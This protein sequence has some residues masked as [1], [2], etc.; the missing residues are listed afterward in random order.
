M[1]VLEELRPMRR[2]QPKGEKA[3]SKP[4]RSVKRK[5]SN[6]FMPLRIPFG[7]VRKDSKRKRFLNSAGRSARQPE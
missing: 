3:S 1:P 4:R 6:F 7:F 2:S 5:G